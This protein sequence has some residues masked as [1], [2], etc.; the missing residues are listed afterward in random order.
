ML[1]N[2]VVLV[3]TGLNDG[4]DVVIEDADGATAEPP[5]GMFA[6]F[7]VVTAEAIPATQ[8]RHP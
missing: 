7:N 5:P 8:P 1:P 6:E 2:S 4:A 3:V